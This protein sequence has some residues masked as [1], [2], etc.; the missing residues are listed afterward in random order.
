MGSADLFF[1]SKKPQNS[2]P[3]NQPISER[4]LESSPSP[5]SGLFA[6][7]PCRYSPVN[8]EE[9]DGGRRRRKGD[10]AMEKMRGTRTIKTRRS[11]FTLVELLIVII[12]IGILA[13]AML[14]LSGS[15]Q[16]RAEATRIISN[17]RTLISAAQAFFT[18]N[19]D[20]ARTPSVA[21]TDIDLLQPYIDRDLQGFDQAS[22]TEPG[23]L[24]LR[25][26]VGTAFVGYGPVP[27]N[28]TTGMGILSGPAKI[29][30]GEPEGSGLL[31]FDF[32]GTPDWFT[33]PAKQPPK[34]N[35]ETIILR[36]AR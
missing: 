3:Y 17:L 13:G 36:R 34:Y 10:Y 2:N 16:D 12:I 29:L 11:G 30:A 9:S 4:G 1:S 24:F 19:P 27:G 26:P 21:L 5:K 23:Y 33:D 25:T 28:P 32:S 31:G 22:P 18:D 14:L 20:Q 15:G 8:R 35:G 7:I 6:R